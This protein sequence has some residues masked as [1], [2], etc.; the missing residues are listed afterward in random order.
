MIGSARSDCRTRGVRARG[1]R[2]AQTISS[3]SGS[4]HA[5]DLLARLLVTPGAK[6]RVAVEES[7]FHAARAAFSRPA[8]DGR[9]CRWTVR[10][11]VSIRCRIEV[12][13]ISVTPSHQ[14]ADG[15]GDVAHS[16]R[17]VARSRARELVRPS[18]RMTTTGEVTCYGKATTGC[19]ADDGSRVTR[20]FTSARSQR[21]CFRRCARALSSRR[22]WARA[23]LIDAG[24]I[25]LTNLIVTLLTQATLAVLYRRRSPGASH[26]SHAADLFAASQ[27]ALARCNRGAPLLLA[28][29]YYPILPVC[30]SPRASESA[31][32]VNV[33]NAAFSICPESVVAHT[34]PIGEILLARSLYR[35]WT[36]QKS[37]RIK[38]AVRE[39][40]QVL[41]RRSSWEISRVFVSDRASLVRQF[42]CDFTA[43]ASARLAVDRSVMR[44]STRKG[45]RRL[46][47]SLYTANDD[48]ALSCVEGSPIRNRERCLTPR[49]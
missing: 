24:S 49:N 4:Q 17:G 43:F 29:R 40:G 25:R 27:A 45:S 47:S 1:S 13:V 34:L 6:R 28:P 20:V 14:S 19:V 5:F 31:F 21:A 41:R 39:M 3:S 44:V 38:R 2:V 22:H 23:A 32:A 37:S 30:I 48:C 42:V 26:S 11:C 7:G 10:V 9:L 46:G 16:A 35:I 15:R 36:R 12:K 18:S 8:R 33:V